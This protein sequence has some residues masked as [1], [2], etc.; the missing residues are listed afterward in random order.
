M[1]YLRVKLLVSVCT[2]YM[3]QLRSKMVFS[4]GLAYTL[5]SVAIFFESITITIGDPTLHAQPV[6]SAPTRAIPSMGAFR[7]MEVFA[8]GFSEN[9]WRLV[10]VPVR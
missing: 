4:V 9:C 7:F 10:G 6:E 1:L 5:A 2:G 3:L 8:T